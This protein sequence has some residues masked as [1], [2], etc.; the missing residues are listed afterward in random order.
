MSSVPRFKEPEAP[1]PLE[2]QDPQVAAQE[3]PRVVLTK[4][5][6][7]PSNWKDEEHSKWA[8][9]CCQGEGVELFRNGPVSNGWISNR[10]RLAE[11]LRIV[12]LKLRSN[13]Y[14]T[15]KF[16]GRGQAG[17]NIGCWHC[18]HPRETLGH[19]LGICPAVQEAR[20]LRHNKL[21]KILAAEGKKCEWTVF[22]EPHLRN[23]AGELHK[24]DLVFVRDGTAL[25]VDV[26]VRY[27]GGAASLLTAAAEKAAKYLDL[28]AQIQELTGAKQVTYF[29][30]LLGARGKWHA[31]NWQVLSKLGLS[32][33]RKEQV[34]RLLSWR[35]LLGSVD[36]VN[37][38]ASRHRQE[39][40]SDEAL[41]PD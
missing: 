8:Q 4:V 22:Y 23:A 29:G 18:T 10:G 41:P 26:T 28:N 20:I 3:A 6:P 19:I 31:D 5:I 24:P 27:E 12:A 13:V 35:A 30:F 25:V 17:T 37:I 33:S 16:L 38:F 34:A 36:M 14:P 21:C 11:R 32:N 2:V 40:L 7:Q 1:K 9:L 39:S 15:R